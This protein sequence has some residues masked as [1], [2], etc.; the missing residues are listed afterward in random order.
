MKVR[1]YIL[2]VLT[3][4][5][6][7]SKSSLEHKLVMSQSNQL[8]LSIIFEQCRLCNVSPFPVTLLIYEPTSSQNAEL[9]T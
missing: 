1:K 3:F 5:F 6:I 8:R 9:I 2:Q 7:V 4:T